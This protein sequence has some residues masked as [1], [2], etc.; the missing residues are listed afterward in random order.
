[1]LRLFK[2]QMSKSLQDEGFIGIHSANCSMKT[3]TKSYSL[4]PCE[5][6]AQNQ[7]KLKFFYDGAIEPK[8]GAP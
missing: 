5:L 8:S 2:S 1:M 4:K 6:N 7:A 3:S